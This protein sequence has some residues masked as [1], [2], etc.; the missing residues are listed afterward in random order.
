MIIA[1]ANPK[2]GVGK[3]TS[4]LNLAVMLN[5]SSVIDLDLHESISVIDSLRIV[6]GYSSLSSVIIRDEKKLIS[7]IKKHYQNEERHLLIDC[8]GFDS[9]LISV[10]IASADLVITPTS[11]DVTELNALR[12][13][14][15]VLNR[16]SINMDKTIYAYAF[17]NRVHHAKNDF[18]TLSGWV[19]NFE[20]L[21]FMNT[22]IISSQDIAKAAHS[23]LSV[24]ETKATAKATLCYKK[25]IEEILK[26]ER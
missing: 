2:G 10:A 5:A 6:G 19:D 16:I 7:E 22:P 23:G 4:I 17:P 26:H 14:N 25:L 13:F 9:D 21:K 24:S 11:D 8:G 3:T 15:D 12:I 1:V 18:S 20:H